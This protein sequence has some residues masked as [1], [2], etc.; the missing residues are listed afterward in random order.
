MGDKAGTAG[1][2]WLAFE[3]EDIPQ[4]DRLCEV[5]PVNL[6]AD[7]IVG[8]HEAG[9]RD[10]GRFDKPFCA[11]ASKQGAM[12]IQVLAPY[13]MIDGELLRLHGGYDITN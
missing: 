9:G 11:S 5:H 12:V 1:I 6:H 13:Q 10:E 3:T 4:I 7:Q 8:L 2:D